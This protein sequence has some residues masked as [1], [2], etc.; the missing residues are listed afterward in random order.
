MYT[1]S[2]RC[3]SH[4]RIS[5]RS[6]EGVNERWS[7]IKYWSNSDGDLHR[8]GKEAIIEDLLPLC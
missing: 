1:R 2:E 6:G 7:M 3:R 5:L 4:T 8:Y